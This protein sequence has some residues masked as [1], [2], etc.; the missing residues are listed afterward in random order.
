MNYNDD[1]KT[2]MAN[3]TSV[4]SHLARHGGLSYL[5][6]PAVDVHQSAVFYERVFGWKIRGRDTDHPGFDDGTGHVSGA[7][8]TD[9]EIAR[10]PGLLPYIYVDA[11]DNTIEKVKAQGGAVVKAP[12]QE[13]DLWVATFRDPAG[14]VL[15]LWQRG[16]RS[17]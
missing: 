9:Q 14:N 2:K 15:G 12:S 8:V 13:G 7:W 16:V 3:P 5:H 11:I 1:Q 10:E 4:E 6:I 17:I